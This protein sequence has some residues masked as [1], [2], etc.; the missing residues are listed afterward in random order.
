MR[1]ITIAKGDLISIYDEG[2]KILHSDREQFSIINKTS[3]ILRMK[4]GRNDIILFKS[5]MNWW[6]VYQRFCFNKD[7]QTNKLTFEIYR[8]VYVDELE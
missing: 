1:E 6:G 4:Q 3:D 7:P 8:D 2:Y 5:R